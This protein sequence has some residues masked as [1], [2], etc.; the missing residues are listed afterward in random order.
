MRKDVN[1]VEGGI[2]MPSNISYHGLSILITSF[3]V[4]IWNCLPLLNVH[5]QMGQ[6]LI[7]NSFLLEK[8]STQNGF[9]MKN[10][11]ISGKSQ[12]GQA[13]RTTCLTELW[14]IEVSECHKMAG[15]MTFYVQNG[16]VDM[17]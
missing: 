13:L 17:P 14:P 8:S 10:F 11:Q 4:P 15:Q 3:E 1:V 16:S 7:L 12:S 5:A 6:A 2:C 9:W